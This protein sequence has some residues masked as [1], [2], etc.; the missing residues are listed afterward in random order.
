MHSIMNDWQ[1]TRR[2]RGE[3]RLS[4]DSAA[5]GNAVRNITTTRGRASNRL[6]RSSMNRT[7]SVYGTEPQTPRA[8]FHWTKRLDIRR[9]LDV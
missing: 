4:I 3:A 5:T 8:Q 9:Y 2:N 1:Q 6:S 7:S